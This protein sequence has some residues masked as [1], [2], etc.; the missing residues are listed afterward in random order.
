MTVIIK[1]KEVNIS[2]EVDVLVVG[3]GPA[4]IGAAVSAAR[5][6][7][8]TLLLEKRGFLGGNIT[9]CYVENCNWFLAGTKFSTHGLYAEIEDGYRLEYGRSHDIR[10]SGNRFSS[11]YLRIY[12]DELMEKE[13][14]PVL[15]HAFVND[16]VME[17][18]RIRAVIIQTKQGPEAVSAAVVIDATG[19]G[20]VA[21]AAG[22]PFKQGRDKDGYCQPGT[23]NFRIAGVDARYLSENGDKLKDI[24][25]KFEKDYLSGR[26]GLE[27]KRKDLPFGRLTRAGMLS[28]INYPCSYKIDPTSSAD[29]S[30][31]ERECRRYIKQFMNYMRNNFHGF[32]GIEL[33]SIA[34]EIGF[35]DSRRIEGKYCLSRQDIEADRQ[36]EDAICVF[37]RM[38]DMLSPDG[39]MTGD[40]ALEGEGNRGHIFVHITGDDD[41]TFQVPYRCLLPVKTANLLVAGRCISATHVAE[42]GIRAVFACMLT[43]QAAGAAAAL[44]VNSKLPPEKIDV[45]KL[46]ETLKAQG[47]RL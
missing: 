46:R 1:P 20:D 31:G 8:S 5:L 2:R 11:E 34:P 19:D 36:F 33:A 9:A 47:L 45:K 29:L 15:F 24:G 28:Y 16:V 25:R 23:L 43:G 3:G 26:T 35:R 7:M 32:E 37:P 6:G 38:Y 10:D 30:R 12:L 39:T 13:G 42:S 21:F 40:G 44:A 14:A 4:G 18:G 27:C 22:V 41:R 17:D